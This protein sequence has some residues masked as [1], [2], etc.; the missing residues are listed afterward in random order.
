MRILFKFLLLFLI[1]LF[2]VLIATSCSNSDDLDA[3][4]Y[5]KTW[6]IHGVTIN[7]KKVVS[8]IKE[9]YEHPGTY[10]INFTSS[11]FN[12]TLASGSTVSGNWKADG[13][14]HT[15]HMD[16]IQDTGV[17]NTELSANIY[18][19]LKNAT[20][21]SGDVNILKISMDKNNFIELSSSN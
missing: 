11:T 14:E 9:I 4:F 6:Y 16:F 20:S 19:I 18:Q 5:G 8:G 7:G 2:P 10:Q 21:Y 15:F 1:V 12:G 13:K 17:N 3:I